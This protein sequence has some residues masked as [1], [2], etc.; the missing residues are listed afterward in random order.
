MRRSRTLTRVLVCCS[1]ATTALFLATGPALAAGSVTITNA[2]PDGSFTAV[3]MSVNLYG[4]SAGTG[5]SCLP[6]ADEPYA[7][8][9][10]GMIPGGTDAIPAQIGEFTSLV[11]N[12]DGGCSLASLPVSVTTGASMSSPYPLVLVNSP[13]EG[14]AGESADGDG[15]I[16]IPDS[17]PVSMS[18]GSGSES[19]SFAVSG[20]AP[21]WYENGDSTLHLAPDSGADDPTPTPLTID[22]ASGEL[23]AVA[24]IADG[25]LG[26]FWATDE[27]PD[28]DGMTTDPFRLTP[29][30]QI[31]SP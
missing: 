16:S 20:D 21:W 11:F 6:T 28:S 30:I 2:D 17:A 10:A 14:A 19:C 29:P 27:E 23:C 9:G 5:I 25:D 1:A 7:A 18:I 3:S 4:V 12:D 31:T 15:Y 24:G 13:G 26:T 22:N 8:E